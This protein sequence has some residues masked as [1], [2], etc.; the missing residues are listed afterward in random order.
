M[1]NPGADMAQVTVEMPLHLN[2]EMLTAVRNG[3]L[4]RCDDPDEMHIR[5]GWLVCAYAV[6][7]ENRR[8]PSTQDGHDNKEGV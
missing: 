3:E 7:V 5:I 4:T 1:T 6:L 2:S 8:I